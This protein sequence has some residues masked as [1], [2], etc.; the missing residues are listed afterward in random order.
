M[1]TRAA[2]TKER[3]RAAAL[4]L[5]EERGYR[6]VTVEEIAAAAS[7]SHMT[8]FRHFPTTE[9]VLMDDPFDPVIAAAIAS[10]PTELPPIERLARGFKALAP[11]LDA[12]LTADA[13]RGIAIA[14]RT[15]ELQAP[16]AANTAETER[17]I[18]AACVDPDAPAEDTAWRIAAAAAL[19]AVTS[20]LLDWALHDDPRP[21]SEI[22]S[23]AA[24]VLVPRLA[25]TEIPP[26]DP[27]DL[28][29]LEE[30]S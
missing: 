13:R 29:T 25:G 15:P 22:V 24:E 11:L 9:R 5:F 21:L 27:R 3:L 18:I 10:Q 8:F 6:A 19:A 14:A 28:I 1:S 20:A 7:V 26:F 2:R 16:M 4:D 12:E 30:P 17:A 23:S